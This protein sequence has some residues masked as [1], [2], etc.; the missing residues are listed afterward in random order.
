MQ[1]LLDKEEIRGVLHAYCRAVDR[2]DAE[3]LRS[4]YHPDATDDHIAVRGSVD[5]FI[6]WAWEAMATDTFVIHNI[7]TSI[8]E[9]EG[10]VAYAE[11]YYES[12]RGQSD[13]TVGG[14]EYLL[15]SG[16][17]YIDR[18]ERRDGGP[19]RIADRVLYREWVRRDLVPAEQAVGLRRGP[20]D[21]S[22][23]AYRRDE[24]SAAGSRC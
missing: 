15:M 12:L 13:D 21:R 8:I 23:L 5:D 16:G 9:L 11:T 2:L 20:R 17:R 22:D 24:L 10:D 19:W 18:F 14:G 6:R 4:L 1:E 7:G 3:L